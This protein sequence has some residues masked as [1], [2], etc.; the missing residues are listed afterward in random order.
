MSDRLQSLIELYE[1]NPDDSFVAYG[2]ALEYIS[3][4]NFDEAEKY[5]SN[6]ISNDPDYL[7]AY[8][9]LAH[10]KE[11]LNKIEEAKDSYKKGIEVA[12]I[13]GELKTASEMEEFLNG[14]E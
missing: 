2:I 6:I 10:V 14:L 9:Q 4:G 13:N 5:L 3:K 8:M 11:N 1:K 12:K 7:P